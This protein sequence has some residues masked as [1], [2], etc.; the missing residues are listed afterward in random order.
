MKRF[1]L[2]SVVALML[3]TAV[4]APVAMAQE[5]GDVDITSV[6]LG[7]GGSLHVEGT[8]FCLQGHEYQVWLEV[9]QTKGNQ[10]V[11][12]GSGASGVH[13]CQFSGLQPFTADVFPVQGSKPFRQGEVVLSK[14]RYI[15]GPSLCVSGSN[16]IEVVEVQ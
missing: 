5:P 13:I 1:A 6:T 15:C 14:F 3:A 11:K 8:I 4:F 2:L 16:G 12:F 7:P 10:P 9:R